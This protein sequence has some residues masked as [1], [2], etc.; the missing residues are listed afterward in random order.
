MFQSGT[1]AFNLTQTLVSRTWD[2]EELHLQFLDAL[3]SIANGHLQTTQREWIV[4]AA[5]S[6]IRNKSLADNLCKAWLQVVVS[7]LP[8]LDPAVIRAR[9]VP[10]ATQ[11]HTSHF[12]GLR[13][14]IISTV[15]LCACIC[16]LPDDEL[17]PWL[18]RACQDTEAPI[19]RCVASCLP[20]LIAARNK[21]T[22]LT[23]ALAEVC[24]RS[25][26]CLSWSRACPPGSYRS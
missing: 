22:C 4:D 21:H 11:K 3:A 18:L 1:S 14:R 13:Q 2:E 19:R 8:S 26:T 9:I 7:V 5:L 10:L 24:D 20:T 16:V 25:L 12:A 23:A 15:L 6:H 17:L